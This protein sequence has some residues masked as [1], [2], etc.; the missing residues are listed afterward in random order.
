M[1]Y[2]T[3]IDISEIPEI[4]RNINARLVFLHLTL[5]AGYHDD[6]R[7]QAAISIRRL[8][9]D[10]GVTISAARH[11]LKLLKKHG[12]IVYQNDVFFV[13]KFVM[14]K[15][16]SPRIRSEKKK[17]ENEIEEREKARKAEERRRR[18]EDFARHKALIESGTN[19]LEEYVKSLIIEAD[20][21]DEEAKLAL[22]RHRPMEAKLRAQM[23]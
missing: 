19:P 8:A 10:A 4:Y 12:L 15:Q 2:T 21:G 6:D 5:K 1:R 16:I 20:N 22:E 9:A 3:I 18:D 13:K 7:D 14:E 11:A 23:K 17:R